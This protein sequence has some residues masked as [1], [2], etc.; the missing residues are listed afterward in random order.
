MINATQL[1]YSPDKFVDREEELTELEQRA[2][3]LL[4]GRNGHGVLIFIGERGVGKTWLRAHW[5]EQLRRQKVP[6]V[7]ID[8]REY[9]GKD[10]TWAVAD[11]IRKVSTAT[12]GP[13]EG[14]GADLAEMS[15]NL[16][17]HLRKTLLQEKGFILFID[18]VYE[19][20]WAMLPLLEDYLLAPLSVEP[21]VL[22]ALA[23]RGRLYPWK[24]PELGV[25]ANLIEVKPFSDLRFTQWQLERQAPQAVGEAPEIHTI[26]RG[27]PLANYLLALRGVNT[28]LDWSLEGLLATIPEDHRRKVREYVEALCVLRDFDE[29]RIPAMLAIYYDDPSYQNWMYAQARRIREEL[30]RWALAHWDTEK[31]SY[32]LDRIIRDIAE[33]FLRQQRPDKWE[34]LQKAAFNLYTRWTQE[35]P[36]T[37]ERWQQEAKYHQQQLQMTPDQSPVEKRD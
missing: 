30:V 25:K 10:P 19:S 29:E 31:R 36:R 3:A 20:E 28:G 15:R 16:F 14:L 18:H 9:T 2:R 13:D 8:L 4:E 37:R 32:V 22:I 11:I 24:T 27:N 21:R 34:A 23:G 5:R 17:A 35:Y 7:W 1:N 12:K 26:T 6:M 33:Q